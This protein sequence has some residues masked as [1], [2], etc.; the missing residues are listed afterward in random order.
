MNILTDSIRFDSEYGQLFE[1]V[2]KNFKD[3]PLPVLAGGLC[4][5]AADALCIS[6]T[7]D[8]EPLRKKAPVLIVCPEEKE[9]LRIK[10]T[11]ERFGKRC[12]FYIA[13]DLTFHNI[14]I[15]SFQQP[16]CHLEQAFFWQARCYSKNPSP[17]RSA[18]G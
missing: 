12:A 14:L 5:G 8:T 18:S 7:E 11:F 15:R 17:L 2:K 4:D 3:K 16:H 6:M 13:R 10:Q 9:C 1:T